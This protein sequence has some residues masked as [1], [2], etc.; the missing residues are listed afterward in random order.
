M[1]A[2]INGLTQGLL[3]LHG[4]QRWPKARLCRIIKAEAASLGIEL[5]PESG[6]LLIASEALEGCPLLSAG[7]EGVVYRCKV[8]VV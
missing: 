5:R 2:P 7:Q 8:E 3:V 1:T 4:E 6:R